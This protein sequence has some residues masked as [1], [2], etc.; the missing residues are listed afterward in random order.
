MHCC[1]L[2]QLQLFELPQMSPTVPQRY[3]PVDGV[4]VSGSHVAAAASPVGCTTHELPMQTLPPVHPPQL[5]GTPHP[6]TSMMPQLFVHVLG[7]QTSESPPPL[8]QTS[9]PVQGEPQTIALPV[10]GSM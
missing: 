6:S 8:T 2:G 5:T 1:P 7:W 9:P 10:H 3:V 4:H